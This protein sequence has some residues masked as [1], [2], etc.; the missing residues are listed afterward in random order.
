MIGIFHH[1]FGRIPNSLS[2]YCLFEAVVGWN[3]FKIL[4]QSL[5]ILSKNGKYLERILIFQV[6]FEFSDGLK[7]ID[8]KRYN[9]SNSQKKFIFHFKIFY[10]ND[11]E[12]D[13]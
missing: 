8:K 2:R 12:I 7:I 4:F 9:N 5:P 11:I 10:Q 13:I 6:N 3:G 1:T